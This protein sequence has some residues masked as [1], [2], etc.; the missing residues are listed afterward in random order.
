MKQITT[1]EK[2]EMFNAAVTQHFKKRGKFLYRTAIEN[3]TVLTIVAG[4]LETMKTV[5]TDS[6]VLR[7]IEI[8]SSAEMYIIDREKFVKRYD[9]LDE[10]YKIDNVI[11]RIAFAKGEIDAFQ[12]EG[13]ESF[14]LVAIWNE[15]MLVEKGDWIARPK[16]G[17]EEDI[18]RI[19][20]DTFKQTYSLFDTSQNNG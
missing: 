5:T 9:A 10:D 3:E 13:D 8:G 12:Y 1:A 6:I 17:V 11:W 7:N 2:I 4:K 20:K 15:P 18:Y 14:T 19:E 16:G